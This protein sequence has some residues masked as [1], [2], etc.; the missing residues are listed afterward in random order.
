ME[1]C[2]IVISFARNGSV[3]D[4]C[5]DVVEVTASDV[6]EVT[7]SVVVVLTSVVVV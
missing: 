3:V 7:A 5:T 4:V 1:S 6:V 2:F